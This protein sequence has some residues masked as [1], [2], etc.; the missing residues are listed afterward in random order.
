MH[1]RA[2]SK[3][4]GQRCILHGGL[5]VPGQK[6]D[7]PPWTP[8]LNFADQL[9]HEE[10]RDLRAGRIKRERHTIGSPRPF[11]RLDSGGSD[12]RPVVTQGKIIRMATHRL[13]NHRS[14]QVEQPG[15]TKPPLFY[16][17]PSKDA[18]LED[19][20]RPVGKNSGMALTKNTMVSELA[21]ARGC[22]TTMSSGCL[23]R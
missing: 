4:G 22:V 19:M 21:A 15:P 11:A 10:R 18:V 23:K 2:G 5:P 13:K 16:R 12:Q 20:R 7:A 6:L 17:G 3:P 9:L 8:A 1:V 14:Q